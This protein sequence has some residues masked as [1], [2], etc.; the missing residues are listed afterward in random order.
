MKVALDRFLSDDH[1]RLDNLL[2]QAASKLEVI[3][4]DSYAEF[5]RGLLRHISMEEK[6]I[7]PAIA[8]MQGGKPAPMSERLRL[9]HGALV[10]LLVPLPTPSIIL[11]LRSILKVHNDSEEK[12]GGLYQMLE[13]LGE[14]EAEE[15]F[16]QLRSVPEV[17][18]LPHNERPIALQ[19]ARRAVER[20]GYKFLDAV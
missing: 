6:V 7:L 12:D 11:T 9:D 17:P 2:E 5:R 19:A 1:E 4:V 3:D 16:S 18:V 20:A 8:R 14:D 10:A 15:L 13:Q